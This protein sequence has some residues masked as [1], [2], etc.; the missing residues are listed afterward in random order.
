MPSRRP[1][2]Q[3]IW[4][5]ARVAD[6]PAGAALTAGP[7]A[8]GPHALTDQV[9][10]LKAHG[11]AAVPSGCLNSTHTPK[12]RPIDAPARSRQI[13]LRAEVRAMYGCV[14]GGAPSTLQSSPPRSTA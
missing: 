2:D 7:R 3:R 13:Q 11:T 8:S 9:R 6:E 12:F 1:R 14:E 4:R 10:R 5:L